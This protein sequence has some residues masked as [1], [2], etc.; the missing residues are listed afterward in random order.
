MG[1]MVAPS[2]LCVL[3][4][5]AVNLKLSGERSRAGGGENGYTDYPALK[6]VKRYVVAR[7]FPCV[8]L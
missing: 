4:A 2:G 6:A 1:Y 8:C 7:R 3:L 5:S